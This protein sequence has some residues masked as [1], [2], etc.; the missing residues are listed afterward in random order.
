MRK[1]VWPRGFPGAAQEG[2]EMERKLLVWVAVA[3]GGGLFVGLLAGMLIGGLIGRY[4]PPPRVETVEVPRIVEK[5]VEVPV[6]KIVEKVVEVPVEKI[7]YRDRPAEPPKVPEN[8][9]LAIKMNRATCDN[10]IKALV[11]NCGYPGYA[12]HRRNMGWSE[13]TAQKLE[14]Q[15]LLV[16]AINIL[17]RLPY[18]HR[19]GSANILFGEQ[20]GFS[21]LSFVPS[22]GK[23]PIEAIVIEGE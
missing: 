18:G 2:I 21:A 9:K 16:Y 15:E 7:V 11:D 20:W 4:A 13:K 19:G 12:K 10:L 22:L 8:G 3:L 5:R 14:G 1:A 17:S 6:E 23:G